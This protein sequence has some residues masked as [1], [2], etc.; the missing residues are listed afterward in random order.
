MES[1][2]VGDFWSFVQS[3][4][5]SA[6]RSIFF[7][8]TNHDRIVILKL[9]VR[10]QSTFDDVENIRLSLADAPIS[11]GFVVRCDFNDRLDR[12]FKLGSLGPPCP[13]IQLLASH[14]PAL[15]Y[16]PY[17]PLSDLEDQLWDHLFP[18]T[19]EPPSLDGAAVVLDSSAS[20]NF[21]IIPVLDVKDL[22]KRRQCAFILSAQSVDVVTVQLFVPDGPCRRCRVGADAQREKTVYAFMK[23]EVI[24][25]LHRIRPGTV[26]AFGDDVHS[27][28]DFERG[29][30]RRR[31]NEDV[32]SPPTLD[33]YNKGASKRTKNFPDYSS[34]QLFSDSGA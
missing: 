6:V 9:F 3:T 2:Y 16:R 11:V 4:K 8:S 33:K 13:V 18:L 29:A 15:Q 23:P 7:T 21:T 24:P 27:C 14:Q 20:P 5:E 17:S 22:C 34:R 31:S 25:W 32:L 19:E 26:F 1:I 30:P 10:Q 28:T 12:Q